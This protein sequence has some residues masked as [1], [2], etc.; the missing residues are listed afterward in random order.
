MCLLAVLLAIYELEEH[1]VCNV[2]SSELVERTW[3][4]EHFAT[5]VCLFALWA[6][7]HGDGIA[8][9]VLIEAS[10]SSTAAKG[11]VHGHGVVFVVEAGIELER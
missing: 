7:Q 1:G 11:L 8:A 5:M 3:W 9:E 2:E 6:R 4:K 10:W